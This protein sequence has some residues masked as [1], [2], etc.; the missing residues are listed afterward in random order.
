M[1]PRIVRD[2]VVTAR[3]SHPHDPSANF[4]HGL[5]RMVVVGAS[6]PDHP[7]AP[8]HLYAHLFVPPY[9]SQ[10]TTCFVLDDPHPARAQSTGT[11]AGGAKVSWRR[12]ASGCDWPLAK[13]RVGTEE[14]ALLLPSHDPNNTSPTDPPTIR[15]TAPTASDTVI[16]E[17]LAELTGA[18]AMAAHRARE[19]IGAAARSYPSMRASLDASIPNHNVAAFLGGSTLRAAGIDVERTIADALA[20]LLDWWAQ[21]LTRA[22]PGI[23][24][25]DIALSND[26]LADIVADHALTSLEQVAPTPPDM[27]SLVAVLVLTPAPTAHVS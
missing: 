26:M 8:T 4:R 21:R 27:E 2:L 25:W 10:P 7:A 13:C 23:D 3:G 20:P 16:D 18:V 24:G 6:Y 19:R 14:L 12:T 17:L 1:S 5:A 9:P 15:P 22:F 11:T